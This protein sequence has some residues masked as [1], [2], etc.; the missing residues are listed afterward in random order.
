MLSS[1]AFTV[2]VVNFAPKASSIHKKKNINV[3]RTISIS[4]TIISTAST[5]SQLQ[6]RIRR[7]PIHAFQDNG[8]TSNNSNDVDRVYDNMGPILTPIAEKL[9]AATGDWALSYADLSPATP[10]TPAGISFLLTNVC[11]ALVGISLISQG[12]LFY[13]T[14]VEIAGIVSFWYHYSQLELGQNRSEVRLALLT[15]YFTAGAALITGGVYM[16]QMGLMTIPLDTLIAAGGSLVA[17]GLCW[18]WEFGYPYLVLHSIWHIGSSYTGYLI[19]Q[20][21]IDNSMM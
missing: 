15:D 13:G 19:G 21:H 10:K 4:N 5:S 8:E 17:L 11:Y 20:A 12:D 16:F 3:G 18:V 1:S 2:H 7:N 6:Q 14:L 9:D